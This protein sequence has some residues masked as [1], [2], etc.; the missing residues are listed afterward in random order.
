VRGAAVA[1][2]SCAKPE[3][4]R[5][6]IR[7]IAA[8]SIAGNQ[9]EDAG[10]YE[11]PARQARWRYWDGRSWTTR[12]SNAKDPADSLRPLSSGFAR[13]SDWLARALALQAVLLL[14]LSGA[15]LWMSTTLDAYGPAVVSA[16]EPGAAGSAELEEDLATAGLVWSVAICGWLLTY[17]TSGV[18][19]LVW[20]ARLAASAPGPVRRGPAMQVVAW[21][22]PVLNLWWPYQDHHDLW[23]AYRPHGT[24]SEASPVGL[25]WGLYLA[26]PFLTGLA[27]PFLVFGTDEQTFVS[28]VAQWHASFFL[29]YAALALVA[30]WVVRRMSWR[31]IELWAL[32]G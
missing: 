21:F 31:A 20:Q 13:L 17:A 32:S 26:L 25:W 5:A 9:V 23:A 7:I 3:V 19:W 18:L 2:S 22:V 10:W 6:R 28:R 16:L 15:F 30:R 1:A 12:T 11:D 29:V 27:L 4:G 8:V 24:D 14:V